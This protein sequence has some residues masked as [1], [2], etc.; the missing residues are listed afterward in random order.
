MFTKSK[1]ITQEGRMLEA[2]KKHRVHGVTNYELSRI[3]LCYTKVVSNLRE[4]GHNIYCERQM[5]RGRYTGT[6]RYYLNSEI[7]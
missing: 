3:A 4:D 5:V 7:L 6:Y 2:L 1:A